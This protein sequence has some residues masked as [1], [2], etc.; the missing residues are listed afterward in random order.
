MKVDIGWAIKPANVEYFSGYHPDSVSRKGFLFQLVGCSQWT[1]RDYCLSIREQVMHPKLPAWPVIANVGWKFPILG[2]HGATVTNLLAS[3][4]PD[5]DLLCSVTVS[6]WPALLSSTSR[7]CYLHTTFCFR[8]SFPKSL[9][10]RY[11]H[12]PDELIEVL[13]MCHLTW[14]VKKVKIW[15]LCS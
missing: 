10:L 4:L 3:G 6:L 1:D 15:A 13:G 11:I 7:E 9:T 14:R 12:D 8:V 2:Q 5:A